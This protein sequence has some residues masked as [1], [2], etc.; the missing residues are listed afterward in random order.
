MYPN[1]EDPI[2]LQ[3]NVM[4]EG[5]GGG[6]AV[7]DRRGGREERNSDRGELWLDEKYLK[8][9]FGIT[10]MARQHNRTT[11]TALLGQWLSS[12]NLLLPPLLSTMSKLI[13][14]IQ[15]KQQPLKNILETL[16]DEINPPIQNFKQ[17]AQIT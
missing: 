15:H 12:T 3:I 2:C 14:T 16:N 7:A 8:N 13:T 4:D 11:S 10:I 9:N 17:N 1:Q 5:G 6:R